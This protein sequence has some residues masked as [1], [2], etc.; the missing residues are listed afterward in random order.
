MPPVVALLLPLVAD[1]GGDLAVDDAGH[2][3]A[4]ARPVGV[5]LAEA[6]QQIQHHLLLQVVVVVAGESV[7]ADQLPGFVPNDFTGVSVEDA[8]LCVLHRNLF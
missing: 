4:E 5:V 7:L 2:E 6:A 3:G 1:Q 8:L